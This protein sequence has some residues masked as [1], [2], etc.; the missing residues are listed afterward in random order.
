MVRLDNLKKV[1]REPDGRL[2]PILDIPS[3]R[4]DSAEQVAMMGRSGSG[5]TSLIQILAGLSL[6][7][8]GHVYFDELDI[9]RL[10]EEERDRF[11]AESIGVIFQTLNLLEGFN[12]LENVLLGMTFGRRSPDRDRALA[13]LERVGLGHR[14]DHRPAAL[15]L[16]ERQRVAVAR[17]LVGRPKLLL[18]DE[19]TAHLDPH[20]Q[21][22]VLELIREACREEQV[23]LLMVT[24]APEVASQ[25]ERVDALESFNR[26]LADTNPTT[27]TPNP[28]G[29]PVKPVVT[30]EES[31][32]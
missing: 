4:I 15:S 28:T 1:Y 11:R 31:L 30:A 17:A 2:I 19:P 7:S 5:K 3:Y 16:G 18:A 9:T 12:A 23:A 10:S 32:T 6:P 14:L 22:Q 8:S 29:T 13:L 24:H 26:V 21:Q 25:F 20:N 27:P